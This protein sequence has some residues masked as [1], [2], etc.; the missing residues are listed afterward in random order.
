MT[1]ALE[2]TRVCRCCEKGKPCAFVLQ[3]D[4]TQQNQ[5]RRVLE[6]VGD[7]PARGTRSRGK[8]QPIASS[9]MVDNEPKTDQHCDSCG[10]VTSTYTYLVEFLRSQHVKLPSCPVCVADRRAA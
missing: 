7:N 10:R 8:S 5:L 1:C 2:P 4:Q 9:A 3:L 6:L